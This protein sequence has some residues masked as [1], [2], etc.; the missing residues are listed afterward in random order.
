MGTVVW[1]LLFFS[2]GFI[3][4]FFSSSVVSDVAYTKIIVVLLTEYHYAIV[5]KENCSCSV[6]ILNASK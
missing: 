1:F 3:F 5:K 2:F 4:E 6:D